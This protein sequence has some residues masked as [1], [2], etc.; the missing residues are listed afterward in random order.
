MYKHILTVII[1][2]IFM[3]CSAPKSQKPPLLDMSLPTWYT[4][5]PQDLQFFYATG[6]GE[7]QIKAK[8]NAISNLRGTIKYNLDKV[9]SSKTTKLKIA[10][11]QDIKPILLENEIFSNTIPMM[12]TKI[13]KTTVFQ[14]EHLTLVK[15]PRSL[16]FDYANKIALKKLEDSKVRYKTLKDKIAIQRYVFL[17]DEMPHYHKLATL[18][19]AKKSSLSTY[20]SDDEFAY[21]NKIGSE[22]YKLKQSISFYVLS[23]VNSRIFVQNAKKAIIASGLT[24]SS[25][26]IGDNHLELF[27]TS[28]TVDAQEYSFNKSK[29]LIKYRTY[30]KNKEEIAFRQH[31]F[32]GKS[33]VSY[34]DAKKQ[35][36]IDENNKI[37]KLGIYKFIGFN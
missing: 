18:I 9:F 1:I 32:I 5:P 36:A 37:K 2:A 11:N 26:P 13:E 16:V 20:K 17:L 8:N 31:T 21:L 19:A 27:I 30:N 10:Q 33:R 14:K 28:K 7:T 3:G 6:S 23:D 12:R 22:F 35:S 29:T 15:L 25:Q 34:L 24:L 4:S